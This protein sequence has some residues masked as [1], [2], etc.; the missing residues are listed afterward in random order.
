[1]MSETT[2][3]IEAGMQVTLHFALRLEDGAEVDSTFNQQPATLTI[4]D[5]NLPE[6]FEQHLLGLKAGQHE[7]FHVAPEQAFGQPNPNNVQR[8]KRSA[9]AEVDELVPGMVLSFA[10]K[11]G[12]ELPGVVKGIE[13]DQV[14]IDFN[15][16]LA[17]RTLVFEV[18]IL[19]VKPITVQ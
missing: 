3:T 18:D 2:L 5:G 16:P 8:M 19:E 6:G 12:G 14:D 15:H 9:F 4:G 7:T 10:D 13:G 11:A 17:G 1:M